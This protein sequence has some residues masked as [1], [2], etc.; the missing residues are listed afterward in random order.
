MI[1][2]KPNDSPIVRPSER[3]VTIHGQES[4]VT[5]P[6]GLVTVSLLRQVQYI[7]AKQLYKSN[8]WNKRG[9]N[10]VLQVKAFQENRVLP[11]VGQVGIGD[12]RTRI[13]HNCDQCVPRLSLVR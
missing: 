1:S 12:A 2:E 6:R 10:E 8:A 7:S 4:W 13:N 9:E 3:A 5:D 11:C